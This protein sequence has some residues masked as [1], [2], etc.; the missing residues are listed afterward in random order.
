[1]SCPASEGKRF[2]SQRRVQPPP[3]LPPP[4]LRATSNSVYGT[5]LSFA[6]GESVCACE[7]LPLARCVT[8]HCPRDILGSS[9]FSLSL[10][11][12]LLGSCSSGTSSSAYYYLLSY[13]CASLSLPL[14]TFRA[15]STSSLPLLNFTLFPSDSSLSFSRFFLCIFA[16]FL[17]T[18][19]P[20]LS[21]SLSLVFHP[22][23]QRSTLRAADVLPPLFAGLPLPYISWCAHPLFTWRRLSPRGKGS[24][25]TRVSS[26]AITQP[27]YCPF[28]WFIKR[29]FCPCFYTAPSCNKCIINCRTCAFF[30]RGLLYNAR[31]KIF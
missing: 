19:A 26:C 14:L 5:H 3:P 25:A 13:I 20:G 31:N 4:F 22:S 12:F 24:S 1:M 18:R 28:N 9:L 23:R 8:C 15:I 27:L 2:A 30:T 17:V 16:L 6:L 7:V 29:H 21:L 10:F 11:F